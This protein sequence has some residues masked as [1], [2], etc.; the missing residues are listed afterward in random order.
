[1]GT[2]ASLIE[3]IRYDLADYQEGLAFDDRLLYNYLNRMITIMDSQLA[4]LDS[5]LVFATEENIDTVA[6]QDYIDCTNMNNTYWDSIR[7]FWIGTDMKEK[8]NINEM[9][10]KRKWY[11]SSQE[12][13]F[14]TQEG[15]R[16]IFEADADAAHTDVVIHYN[17][18]H[19]PRLESWSDTFTANGGTDVI[20]LASGQATFATGDGP[21]TLSTS[22]ADLPAGLA[23]STNYWLIFDCTDTDGYQLATSKDNALAG[24]EVDITDQGTG[25]HTIT[26]G[27]DLMPYDGIF[28]EFFRE[29]LLLYSMDKR[30]QKVQGSFGTSIFKKRAFEEVIRRGYAPKAYYIDF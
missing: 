7:Q 14:W 27:S 6:D 10:V 26:L 1:M 29:M 24:T 15:R 12:P 16:I 28:D 2:V 19:R 9:Y 8:L 25:T 11:S 5:E 21:F 20:T 17:K 30:G 18:K 13:N 23:V 4:V 3:D 22:A